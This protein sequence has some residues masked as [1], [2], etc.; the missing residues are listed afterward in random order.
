MQNTLYDYYSSKGQALPSVADRTGDAAKAGITGTYTGTADQNNQLLSY[1]ALQD[2]NNATKTMVEP[3]IYKSGDSYVNASG[4]AVNYTPAFQSTTQQNRQDQN[5]VTMLNGFTNPQQQQQQQPN[6][7]TVQQ[8]VVP[9]QTPSTP[10]LTYKTPDGQGTVS[11]TPVAGGYQYQNPATL[12]EGQK[13]G[14]GTDGKRYIINKDGSVTNDV[15]ADREYQANKDSIDSLN[16][17]NTQYDEAKKGLDATHVAILL[18]PGGQARYMAD[19]NNGY[20]QKQEEDN[21]ANLADID[22]KYNTLLLQAVQANNKEDFERLDKLNKEIKDTVDQKQTL[23]QKAYADSVNYTKSL[24]DQKKA[25]LDAEKQKYEQGIKTLTTSGPALLGAY[26][27]IKTDKEKQAFLTDYATKLGVE[28]EMVLGAI[29]DQRTQSSKDTADLNAKNRSN[30]KTTGTGSG[31]GGKKTIQDIDFD[32]GNEPALD[33]NGFFTPISVG[34][35]LDQA[36]ANGFKRADVLD[37]I[38]GRL[39][40]KEL[41]KYPLTPDEKKKFNG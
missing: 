41:N 4:Q 20:L 27:T 18:F 17:I 19:I 33:D 21:I 7:Q 28:P 2:K 8:P 34:L 10:A 3:G 25:V 12:Q 39:Y 29:E 36:V 9:G 16:R 26:D 32:F 35:M 40:F 13:S 14:Y 30:I 22:V 11:E 5:N 23:I 38:K 31:S 15:F 37:M 6:G 1:Y 24:N